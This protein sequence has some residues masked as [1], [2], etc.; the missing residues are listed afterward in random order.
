M[1][2]PTLTYDAYCGLAALRQHPL[3][4]G[5]RIGLAGWSL[6]GGATVYAGLDV[7]ND[8]LNAPGASRFAAHLGMYPGCGYRTADGHRWTPSPIA[9][10]C[11][12]AD[13]YTPIA[14]SRRCAARI[15]EQG[16]SAHVVPYEFGLHSFDNPEYNGGVMLWNPCAP[17]HS[18]PML[19]RP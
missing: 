11:G 2:V 3:I 5:S 17:K 15:K 10:L 6:G 4:D 9:L 12:T 19:A 8:A 7:V 16:G 13:D 14:V 1:T 18:C